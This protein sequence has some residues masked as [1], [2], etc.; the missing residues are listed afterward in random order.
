[1]A[2]ELNLFDEKRIASRPIFCALIGKA[3]LVG[4]CKLSSGSERLRIG[5]KSSR[6]KARQVDE[7]ASE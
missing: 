7:P 1:V 5:H 6:D 3:G 2:T 4:F